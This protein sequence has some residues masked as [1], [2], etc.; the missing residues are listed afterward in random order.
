MSARHLAMYLCRTLAGM[1]LPQ[2]G[3]VFSRDHTTV[4]H[5]IRRI[6]RSM[7]DENYATFVFEVSD[8]LKEEHSDGTV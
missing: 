2:I 7:G 3:S 5:G 4:L 1:S 6:A 8:K